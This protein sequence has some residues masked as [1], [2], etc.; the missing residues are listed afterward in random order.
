MIHKIGLGTVQFGADYGIANANGKVEQE[1][2]FRILEYAGLH[3]IDFLDTAYSYGE[4]EK[5][6]GEFIQ[7]NNFL[8]NIIS[9]IPSLDQGFSGKIEEIL[10]KSLNCLKVKNIYGYLIHK[11]EDYVSQKDLWEQMKDLKAKGT[12][13]R[14]GFS[15]YSLEE[16]EMLFS[17]NVQFDILQVPFSLFD[18]RFSVYF[19]KLKAMGVEIH[20]RSVFLQGLAFLNPEDLPVNLRNAKEYI[21]RLRRIAFESKSSISSICLN[22]ALLNPYVDKVI[23]GIDS[24]DQLKSNIEDIKSIK[25]VERILN[26]LDDLEIKDEE[27]ILPYKWTKVKA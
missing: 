24:L 14:I 22:F 4:S 7:R 27:I 10:L 20:V 25:K 2:V 17:Q 21:L 16:L 1:E 26:M 9:K 12:V 15:L 5:V 8:F 18:R 23:I 6:L 3:E 11:F 13:K 19:K